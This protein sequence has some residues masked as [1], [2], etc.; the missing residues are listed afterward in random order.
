MEK[1]TFDARYDTYRREVESYLE[2]LFVDKP[3]WSDLYES[4]R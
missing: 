1:T 3:H 4:M 2:S